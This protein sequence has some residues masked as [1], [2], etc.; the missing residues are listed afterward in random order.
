[1]RARQRAQQLP[2]LKVAHAHDARPLVQRPAPPVPGAARLAIRPI[3][4]LIRLLV[5]EAIARQQIDVAASQTARLDVAQP[6]RQIE[7]RLKAGPGESYC[8]YYLRVGA[9]QE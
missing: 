2:A 1:M 5:G 9:G 7:Q 3:V 4:R 6:L 8:D